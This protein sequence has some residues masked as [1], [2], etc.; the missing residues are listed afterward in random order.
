MKMSIVVIGANAAGAKAASKAKRINPTAEITLIDRGTFISYGA[1]GI[2][3]FVSDTV[4]DVKELMSTPVG[5]V[6][7]H[8]FFRK[9][10]GVTVKTATEVIAIDRAAKTVC[11]RDCQTSRETKLPY[12]RLV[13]ATGSTPFIPQISNVN[14][15][16]VLTVKSIEDAEL[17][18]SLAVPGT[19]ACIVGGGLI[20]LETAEAL[21]HKGLQV[22]VVEMRDQMLPG[23]LDWEMAALVEKQLRQQGVTVMTGSAVTGLVGDA[24]VEA[25]QIGDVRIPADLV[26]LAPGV[27][28]NVELARGAGLEIGPTGAIAVDTR[29]CTTDPDIYACGDCCE[30][31]HLIT[32]KKVFIPLGSTANKQG[33]VA[34]INAAGGEATF[35]GVIGTSILRVFAVN[36]GKTGLTEAEAKAHGFEV[37]TVLS[38][39]HD[40]AHFFPGAKPIILKL[41][42][43]RGTGRILGLQ[44]VGEGAVDKRLDAAATAITFGATAEQV[45]QL[46]LAYAPPY[47]AAMDNLIVAADILKNKLAG[48]A[49]GITPREV[50]RKFDEGDDFI[51]LDVR[52]PAEHNAVGIEGAK[53]IPLGMLREKLEELPRDKEIIA[54]CKISL[55]GYEAQK[56][57]DAAGFRNAK[58]M[59]GGILAWPFALRTSDK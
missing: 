59:D 51:L 9:V 44:A 23:V 6:R 30:T 39:S 15:A 48:H 18:K 55:R 28:P 34:G 14:L 50:K 27:A 26:V 38:P 45:A 16:N 43:E 58:F 35:A 24:A 46:D 2:P 12:D 54:F 47:S 5:V 52:S 17:L 13:L 31:T 19:R 8:Q 57:L 21:R 1:C 41:V 3:Y 40:K 29:Q 4:E 56:I 36:A 33:R 49:R 53:L 25:V 22:A 42:A 32:G 10:K 7:D 37:E 20:G 11:M